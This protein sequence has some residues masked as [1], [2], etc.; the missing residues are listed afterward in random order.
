MPVT[1][2]SIF[3]KLHADI[4]PFEVMEALR[5]AETLERSGRSI[6]H[7]SGGIPGARPPEHVMDALNITMRTAPMAYSE[8]R[9]MPDMRAAMARYYADMYGLSI[10]PDHICMTSGSSAGFVLALLASC[11]P[12]QKVGLAR[13]YYPAYPNIFRALGLEPV[14][15]DTSAENGFQPTA[16]DIAP[17][18]HTLSAVMIGSPANPTGAIIAPHH[19][20]EIAALCDRHN[21]QLISDEI[22]H[23]I[24]VEG[25]PATISARAVSEQAIVVSSFSKYHLLPGW[26]LGW[27]I[28]PEHLVR[29]VELLSQNM[30]ICAPAIS[31]YIG[32]LMLRERP[33]MD[34]V[35]QS[36][37]PQRQ[38][39]CATLDS[40]A[41]PYIPP[42]GA[43]YVYADIAHYLGGRLADSRQFCHALLHEAGV[44]A[45]PGVDFDDKEGWH[46]VRFSF[47]A[48]SEQ[49]Q[50][51]CNH[52]S[53]WLK[54]L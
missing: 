43:F 3:H 30:F 10:N 48:S 12:G 22:Y 41:I 52:L 33:Y 29:K 9:G 20:Q 50:S 53:D 42:Q 14:I 34:S 38:L 36:Y 17:H 6:V 15:L 40:C 28:T 39:L 2:E 25:A 44:C 21:V 26:R 7:L 8:S 51:A 24:A 18:I 5:D 31:Q 19:L 11:V 35:V 37:A 1:S 13:P 45:I 4:K 49:V 32:Q 23:H 47:C 27:L 46:Y 16:A 54:R